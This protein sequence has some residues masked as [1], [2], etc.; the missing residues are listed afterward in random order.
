MS[1]VKKTAAKKTVK[2]AGRPAKQAVVKKAGRPPK[3][4]ESAVQGGLMT[5]RS[6]SNALSTQFPG[7]GKAEAYVLIKTAVGMMV[8]ALLDGH[9]VEFRG[10]GVFQPVTRKPR[11]ARNPYT[12]EDK[13]FMVPARNT[14][15]F[16]PSTNLKAALN[17]KKSVRG[18]K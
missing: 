1:P 6:L 4:I 16:K 12:N 9:K 18:K 3:K 15:R 7:I 10:F 11:R 14:V 13:T 17:P 5:R 2:K 8:Q